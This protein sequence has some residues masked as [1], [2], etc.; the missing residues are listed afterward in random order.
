MHAPVLT[1]LIPS[2]PAS[3]KLKKR[4]NHIEDVNAATAAA[5]WLSTHKTTLRR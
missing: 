5:Q 4:A 2:Q 1:L 3:T